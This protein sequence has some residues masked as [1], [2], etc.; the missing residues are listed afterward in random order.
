MPRL[1]LK[2]KGKKSSTPPAK[3]A[4]TPQSSQKE[5]NSKQ[6]E[7]ESPSTPLSPVSSPA[8]KEVVSSNE[9]REKNKEIDSVEE[10]NSSQ[11]EAD[12]SDHPGANRQLYTMINSLQGRSIAGLKGSLVS[13]TELVASVLERLPPNTT[14]QPV[15]VDL[16][17][18]N[19]VEPVT[20]LFSREQPDPDT[21]M[22]QDL[23]VSEEERNPRVVAKRQELYATFSKSHFGYEQEER[24]TLGSPVSVTNNNTLRTWMQDIDYRWYAFKGSNESLIVPFIR[25][26]STKNTSLQHYMMNFTATECGIFSTMDMNTM[27]KAIHNLNTAQQSPGQPVLAWRNE[28]EQ[29]AMEV[30]PVLATQPCVGSQIE[31]RFADRHQSEAPIYQPGDKVL[32]STKHFGT[33]RPKPKWADKWIGPYHILKEAH[34]GSSSYVLSLP[35]SIKIYPVFH[36]SLLIPYVEN[37]LVGWKRPAPPPIVINDKQEYEVEAILYVQKHYG[38]PQYL[39]SWKGYGPEENLWLPEDNLSN[40]PDL[41]ADFKARTTCV[42]TSK[43]IRKK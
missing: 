18:Q 15:R 8:N 32:L 6:V 34:P 35:P 12:E 4:R 13:I 21:P 26:L 23:R 10:S 1:L 36:S 30:S 40:S 37:T 19:R 24:N 39:V 7:E 27:E 16:A 29:K 25:G 17:R 2:R 5:S 9:G 38:K 20:L 22:P 33:L 11:S 43:R 41:I 31:R 3:V 14:V 42:T 28:L